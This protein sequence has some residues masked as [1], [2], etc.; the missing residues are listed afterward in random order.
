MAE[1]TRYLKGTPKGASEMCKIMEDMRNEERAEGLFSGIL[2]S[3]KNLVKNMGLSV[4]Q[5][6]SILEVPEEEKQKY[7]DLLKQ[8]FN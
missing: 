6:M 5:A 1:R 7:R 8:Q 4:E 3:I 2:S